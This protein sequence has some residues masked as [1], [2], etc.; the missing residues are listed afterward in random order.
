MIF[1]H[2]PDM[3]I[4]FTAALYGEGVF[5]STPDTLESS[6]RALNYTLGNRRTGAIEFEG[7]AR[8]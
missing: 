5:L 6:G 3:L 7:P 8:P 2:R 4:G 1:Q